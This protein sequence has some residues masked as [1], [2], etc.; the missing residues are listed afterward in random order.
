[1]NRFYSIG[2]NDGLREY[3]VSFIVFTRDNR[4]VRF[5]NEAERDAYTTGYRDGMALVAGRQSV[6]SFALVA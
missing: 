1:M 6:A 5:M 3:A 2:H 4:F